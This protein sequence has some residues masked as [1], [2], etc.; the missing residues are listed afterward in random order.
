MR[1]WQFGVIAGG[2][3]V[4]CVHQ[5]MILDEL[6]TIQ[7]R[8]EIAESQQPA[9]PPQP[10]IAPEI[11]RERPAA[12]WHAAIGAAREAQPTSAPSAPPKPAFRVPRTGMGR[13]DAD[14]NPITVTEARSGC[15]SC[16]NGVCTIRKAGQ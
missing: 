10:V 7:L 9:S 15:R 13:F 11:T 4:I 5:H 6:D 2:M 3:L 12:E 16:K 8:Q 1:S 14:G